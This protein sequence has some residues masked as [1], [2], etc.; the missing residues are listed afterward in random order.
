MKRQII[1][2]LSS[3]LAVMMF[4]LT[5]MSIGHHQ[6]V[7]TA[8]ATESKKPVSNN[9]FMALLAALPSEAFAQN[10]KIT[11]D[12]YLELAQPT[13]ENLKKAFT[14]VFNRMDEQEKR[15]AIGGLLKKQKREEALNAEPDEQ[16]KILQELVALFNEQDIALPP[17]HKIMLT[18]SEH[19]AYD[20]ATNT[21]TYIER[22][23][24]ME[25]KS[26]HFIDEKPIRAISKVAHLIRESGH[27]D[28]DKMASGL[29]AEMQ[30]ISL[31]GAKPEDLFDLLDRA[32][33]IFNGKVE[34]GLT[35]E[36][37][38]QSWKN[39]NGQLPDGLNINAEGQLSYNRKSQTSCVEV[40]GVPVA[41]FVGIDL[42]PFASVMT[43]I[44]GAGGQTRT[45]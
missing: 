45:G 39:N 18:R 41:V 14:R 21:V 13:N 27:P 23:S 36:Q 38:N 6:S 24:T 26:P 43:A 25:H 3:A 1:K 28:A 29:E 31:K 8:N 19:F 30:K 17:N 34:N 42:I 16:R 37:R 44:N 20:P 11:S 2:G 5:P 32:I 35:P 10:E 4:S 40:G 33:D 9:A 22:S 15:E 7:R 12:R